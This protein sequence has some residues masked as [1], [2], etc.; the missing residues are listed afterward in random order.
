MDNEEIVKINELVFRFKLKSQS[1]VTLEKIFGKNIF[2]AFRD[3]SFTNIQTILYECL[4][5]KDELGIDKN[6]M[7][8]LLLTKYSLLEI[9]DGLMTD[10]AVKSGLLKQ[11]EVNDAEQSLKN[12]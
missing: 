9:P 6:E 11:E 1:I 12:A 5:N 10:I 4:I 8:D 2:E 7:M 3:L